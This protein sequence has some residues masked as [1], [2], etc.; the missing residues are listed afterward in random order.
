M[1]RKFFRGPFA[2]LSGS[3]FFTPPPNRPT[4]D[5][6][7]I[8]PEIDQSMPFYCPIMFSKGNLMSLNTFLTLFRCFIHFFTPK[9]HSEV[10]RSSKMV[11][12]GPFGPYKEKWL[13]NVIFHDFFKVLLGNLRWCFRYVEMFLGPLE[14]V[15]SPRAHFGTVYDSQ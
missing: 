10:M 9:S 14:G 7:W 12:F 8:F 4:R 6:F 15:L 5:F 2:P 13:K 3:F 11:Y 1:R